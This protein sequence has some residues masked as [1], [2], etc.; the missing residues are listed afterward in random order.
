MNSPSHLVT[1]EAQTTHNLQLTAAGVSGH[2]HTT[3]LSPLLPL[4]VG[5]QV[6]PCGWPIL[7]Y[8]L[9]SVLSASH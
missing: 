2:F 9:E 7:S 5:L 6:P 1:D 4:S 8:F 3:A